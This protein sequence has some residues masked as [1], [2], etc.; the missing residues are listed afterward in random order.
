LFSFTKNMPNKQSQKSVSSQKSST[1]FPHHRNKTIRPT[2]R[3]FVSEHTPANALPPVESYTK[4]QLKTLNTPSHSPSAF[5]NRA[6]RV[7]HAESANPSSPFKSLPLS[8]FHPAKA[9][10]DRV[11]LLSP[12]DSYRNVVYAIIYLP[13]FPGDKELGYVGYTMHLWRRTH[14]HLA[15]M[16][17]M[18]NTLDKSGGKS[19]RSHTIEVSGIAHA[20]NAHSSTTSQYFY[21]LASTRTLP[22]IVVPLAVLKDPII[23]ASSYHGVLPSPKVRAFERILRD[24]NR[25]VKLPQHEINFLTRS[26]ATYE[27][28]WIAIMKTN[29]FGYNYNEHR[30]HTYPYNGNGCSS[31]TSKE[32]GKYPNVTHL[33]KAYKR[34]WDSSQS[35]HAAL[36]FPGVA[37]CMRA[38]LLQHPSGN[39]L[40]GYFRLHTSQLGQMIIKPPKSSKT[41]AP[42]EEDLAPHIRNGIR[43]GSGGLKALGD[44]L[45]KSAIVLGTT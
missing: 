38:F 34:Q 37:L 31:K 15:A 18:A 39:D 29:G 19:S 43:K 1:P 10:P 9:A 7:A 36:N 44:F 26:S 5:L 33:K 6:V 20:L 23:S 13:E 3:Y 41:P 16:R 40:P 2:G 22:P 4:A 14:G 27:R 30:F 32:A 45:F 21:S 17:I 12:L 42:G 28:Y 8:I 24:V 35:T 11:P 25:A